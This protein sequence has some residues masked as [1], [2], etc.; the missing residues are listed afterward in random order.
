ML[1]ATI[2]DGKPIVGAVL[3]ARTNWSYGTSHDVFTPA[4]EMKKKKKE[5]RRRGVNVRLEV[6]LPKSL[7]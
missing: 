1:I 2:I 5:E 6:K 7:D 4:M 3:L